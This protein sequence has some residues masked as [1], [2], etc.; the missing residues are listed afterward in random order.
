M[1]F[2]IEPKDGDQFILN[3]IT[4][5]YNRGSNTWVDIY[6][7]NPSDIL[8]CST[9]FVDCYF[10]CTS[11]YMRNNPLTRPPTIDD[12]TTAVQQHLDDF[13][14]TRGYDSILSACTYATSNIPKFKA[15]GQ[16]CVDARDAAWSYCYTAMGEI[17]SGTKPMYGGTQELRDALPAL[18]WPEA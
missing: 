9:E 2:P 8:S 17:Q 5:I 14:K 4:Y 10:V 11:N 3:S 7:Q 16:Y 1:T 6:V 15:E 12:F 18:A 13:A